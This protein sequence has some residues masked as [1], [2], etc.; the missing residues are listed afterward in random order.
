MKKIFAA[1]W[2]MHKNPCEAEVFF[3]NWSEKESKID[4]D[5]CEIVFFPATLCLETSS[6]L[7]SGKKSKWGAQNSFYEDQG[8][9]TGENSPMTI[10]QMGAEYCLVGH[11]ER[12]SLFFES[13]ELLSKKIAK[14]Q[15]LDLIPM[16]CVGETLEQR[17]NN[18][19][20]DVLKKQVVSGLSLMDKN[21]KLILAYEPVWAI[22]TGVVA[23]LEQ[24]KEV[25]QFLF[26]LLSE[27]KLQDKVPILYGGSVKADNAKDLVKVPHVDGFLIGGA[28]LEVNSF[29]SIL[30]T[31]EFALT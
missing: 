15:A 28:S 21:K 9:F 22:G 12:R 2:K 18:Q 6:R 4:S 5:N 17:K 26:S 11:S 14:L 7:L 27:M 8:A 20:M 24:V 25:H 1:N 10:K 16:F 31:T 30:Q 29:Y 19:T 23:S 13:D 3:Q